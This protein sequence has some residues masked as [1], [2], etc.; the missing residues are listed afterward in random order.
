M[1]ADIEVHIDFAPGLKRVGTLYRHSG[2]GEE[3]TTFEY[4]PDWL[5]DPARFS[6]EPALSL[7]RGA[8]LLHPRANH[9]SAPLEILRQTL[10]AAN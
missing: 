1:A 7:G 10:G 6:L 2:R 9:F 4:H 8:A 5:A 3:T